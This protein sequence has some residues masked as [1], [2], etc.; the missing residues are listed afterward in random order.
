MFSP[1]PVRTIAQFS[2]RDVKKHQDNDK[3]IFINWVLLIVRIVDCH[4]LQF[5]T[6]NEIVVGAC[7]VITYE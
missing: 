2:L 6:D 4:Y 7:Y 3:T 5:N 1:F